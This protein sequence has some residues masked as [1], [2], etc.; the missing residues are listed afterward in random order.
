ME[1]EKHIDLVLGGLI[2]PTEID[3]LP[4]KEE[5]DPLS[6]KRFVK[7]RKV[8]DPVAAAFICQAL[9]LEQEAEALGLLNHH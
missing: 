2:P 5:I 4:A 6:A 9:C 1:K 8:H 3:H 7:G